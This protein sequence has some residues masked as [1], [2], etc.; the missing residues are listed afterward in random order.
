MQ[1]TPHNTLSACLSLCMH[2]NNTIHLGCITIT[3]KQNKTPRVSKSVHTNRTKRPKYL[4]QF[5]PTGKKK[6]PE[7]ILISISQQEKYPKCLNQ[8]MSTGQNAMNAQI[9]KYQQKNLGCL[10]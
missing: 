2:A 8:H 7:Y 6:Q 9:S 1:T 4:I 10:N 3:G 5:I